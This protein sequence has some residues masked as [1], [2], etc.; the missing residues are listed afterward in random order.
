LVQ[1]LVHK[2]QEVV[3]VFGREMEAALDPRHML[4][5][6]KDIGKRTKEFIQDDVGEFTK[7]EQDK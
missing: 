2:E 7:E 5:V 4:H 3:N 1:A 6:L